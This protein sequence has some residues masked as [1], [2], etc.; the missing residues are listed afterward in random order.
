M[1]RQI[2][3]KYGL[4][5]SRLD[6][7]IDE[8]DNDYGIISANVERALGIGAKGRAT[9]TTPTP[10]SFFPGVSYSNE[11]SGADADVRVY[12]NEAVQITERKMSIDRLK[13]YAGEP[14][15]MIVTPVLPGRA[16][17]RLIPAVHDKMT[18][19]EAVGAQRAVL[20]TQVAQSMLAQKDA[21]AAA[22]NVA[23]E[24]IAAYQEE[25]PDYDFTVGTPQKPTPELYDVGGL[26]EELFGVSS[27]Q[28]QAS[29]NG[30]AKDGRQQEDNNDHHG[31]D[32]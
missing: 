11:A 26:A 16:T 3:E 21:L 28:A 32:G 27:L 20:E 22:A 19:D 31:S 15:P 4:P 2:A 18:L 24:Q 9:F 10:S 17:P 25:H 12:E 7:L 6:E 23:G 14:E 30:D 13:A 5:L 8:R 1:L 29:K